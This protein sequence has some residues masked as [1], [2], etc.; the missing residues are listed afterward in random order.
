MS[1]F[2]NSLK[3]FCYILR[4]FGL[5]SVD[6][7]PGPF[8]VNKL[9]TAYSLVLLVSYGWFH[10]TS[11]QMDLKILAGLNFVTAMIDYYNKYS[12]FL[13]FMT[14]ILVT[15]FNQRHLIKFLQLI[16]DHDQVLF[17]KLPVKEEINYSKDSRW[18]QRPAT[19]SAPFSFI[20]L[21]IESTT[22]L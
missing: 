5:N 17:A 18:A 10:L 9:W 16:E 20:C 12:G 21:V 19:S 8:K 6:F 11:A 7:S 1:E 2:R 22:I 14:C 3:Y 4:P 13:L 15:Q